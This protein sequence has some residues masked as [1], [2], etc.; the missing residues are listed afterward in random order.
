MLELY[1]FSAGFP[2]FIV[3][4]APVP[5]A[6]LLAIIVFATFWRGSLPFAVALLGVTCVSGG[7]FVMPYSLSHGLA[8]YER[9][10]SYS[11]FAFTTGIG[12][13]ILSLVV[14]YKRD[15]LYLKNRPIEEQPPPVWEEAMAR[16]HMLVPLRS[17]LSENELYLLPSYSYVIVS[18]DGVTYF[19]RPNDAVPRSSLVLRHDGY[20][21]GLRKISYGYF[22]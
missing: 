8:G 22:F 18:I 13:L 2:P 5:V 17:L 21:T 11:T 4:I 3:K 6:V 14:V 19:V 1:I 16:S 9:L 10:T 20:F 15:W 7:M 12:T